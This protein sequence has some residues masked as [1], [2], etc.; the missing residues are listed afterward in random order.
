[1]NHNCFG[2]W[3]CES[4]IIIFATFRSYSFDNRFRIVTNFNCAF[5]NGFKVHFAKFDFT[6]CIILTGHRTRCAIQ[7]KFYVKSYLIVDGR[8]YLLLL[9]GSASLKITGYNDLILLIDFYL[10]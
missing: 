7:Y 5:T 2:T 8:G 6:V 4:K 9:I 10:T 3:S 1:M